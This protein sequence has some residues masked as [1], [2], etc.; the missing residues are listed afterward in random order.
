MLNDE[1]R[2]MNFEVSIKNKTPD[3]RAKR[4]D[5]RFVYQKNKTPVISRSFNHQS[6]NEPFA[7]LFILRFSKLLRS[8]FQSSPESFART[9]GA[10][11]NNQ[12]TNRLHSCIL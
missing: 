6:K 2:M 12:K 4:T 3:T 1:Q 10:K 11:H 8:K 9:D 7:R 5:W